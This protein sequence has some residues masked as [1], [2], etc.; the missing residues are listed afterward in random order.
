[1]LRLPIEAK[2]ILELMD[3]DQRYQRKD[4][5]VWSQFGKKQF[6]VAMRMLV[7]EKIV[8]RDSNR[9][10]MRWYRTGE[11]PKIEYYYPPRP[12]KVDIEPLWRVNRFLPNNVGYY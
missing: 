3:P 6:E 8:R 1:M 7:D 4:L 10:N 5:F 12:M 2:T 11:L 9:R